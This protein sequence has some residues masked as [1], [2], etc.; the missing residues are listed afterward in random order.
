M[1][2][3]W[4]VTTMVGATMVAREE[5]RVEERAMERWEGAQ[6]VAVT[7]VVVVS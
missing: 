3:A 6:K 7:T 2:V 1:L 4:E 5:E